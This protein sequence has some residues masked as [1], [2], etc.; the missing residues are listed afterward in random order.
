[1]SLL[2]KLDVCQDR[3]DYGDRQYLLCRY[4]PF[5]PFRDQI[6]TRSELEVE[7][8]GNDPKVSR[9]I[10]TLNSSIRH[11]IGVSPDHRVKRTSV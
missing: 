10:Q 4:V 6:A 5:A 7:V 3:R 1:M 8:S 2:Q 9:A 11:D